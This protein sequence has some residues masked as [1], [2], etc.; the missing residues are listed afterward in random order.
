MTVSGKLNDY[1]VTGIA[2]AF[3]GP[4]GA[5]NSTDEIAEDLV[6]QMR[7]LG[8]D[9]PTLAELNRD[10]AILQMLSDPL[11]FDNPWIRN[12]WHTHE[13]VSWKKWPTP[14][15][16]RDEPHKTSPEIHALLERLNP[17][18][19]DAVNAMLN[20]HSK[21]SLVIIQGP[22]GTG[23]TSVISTFVSCAVNLF[24]QSGIWLVAQ[25]NVAVKNIAEKLVSIGFTN[26]RLLVS[27]DFHFGWCAH[28]SRY[29]GHIQSHT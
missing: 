14:I 16:R 29:L 13:K 27:R 12:I 10:K 8:R 23:K 2:N 11:M 15:A 4:I 22:P 26:W 1:V 28:F 6:I 25:S 5:I 17:S 21:K 7:S 3:A 19:Q 9:D 20:P 24:E 18:Q